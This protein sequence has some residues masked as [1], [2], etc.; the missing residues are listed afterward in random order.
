VWAKQSVSPLLAFS[1]DRLVD[2]ALLS[3]LGVIDEPPE[4]G[5][6]AGATTEMWFSAPCRMPLGLSIGTVTIGGRLHVAY[7][8]RHPQ[9]D[10]EAVARF[11]ARY[12]KAIE[13]FT[14]VRANGQ[15][16]G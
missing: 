3:N 2:T 16:T 5:P 6:D 8:Y 14:G 10:G 4:F 15:G 13:Q 9:F 7:R 1:G 11:S 12:L